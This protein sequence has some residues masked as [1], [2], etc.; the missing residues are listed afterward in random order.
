MRL[1]VPPLNQYTSG[2]QNE[3][4]EKF[5]LMVKPLSVS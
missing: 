1:F 4:F 2:G 5:F 3:S